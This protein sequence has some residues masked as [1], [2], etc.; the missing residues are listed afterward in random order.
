[1]V[2]AF[3]PTFVEYGL[4]LSPGYDAYLE[5]FLPAPTRSALQEQTAS[6]GTDCSGHEAVSLSRGA[7]APTIT[8]QPSDGYGGQGT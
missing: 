7:T 2:C 3:Y 1:M 5:R 4:G 8:K 6:R